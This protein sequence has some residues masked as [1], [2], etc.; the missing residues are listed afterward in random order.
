MKTKAPVLADFLDCLENLMEARVKKRGPSS[1]WTEIQ[2]TYRKGVEPM[3]VRFV[4]AYITHQR[5]CVFPGDNRQGIINETRALFN[6]RNETFQKQS[7][8]FVDAIHCGRVNISNINP[9]GA[10]QG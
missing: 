2:L 4:Q 6:A 8:L 10:G 9:F 5:I 7:D 3:E 1:F